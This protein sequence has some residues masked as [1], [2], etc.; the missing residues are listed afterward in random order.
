MENSSVAAPETSRPETLPERYA[1]SAEIHWDRVVASMV[2]ERIPLDI[3]YSTALLAGCRSGGALVSLAERLPHLRRLVAIDEDRDLLN[4]AHTVA[5]GIERPP[6]FFNNQSTRALN[7]ADN[8]F[9]LAVCVSGIATMAD[10]M[11]T[12]SELSRVVRPGGTVAMAMLGAESFSIIRE[13]ME[14]SA[15]ASGDVK[16]DEILADF[17]HARPTQSEVARASERFELQDVEVW[18]D[19]WA[20]EL[21]DAKSVALHPLWMIDLLEAW[22]RSV[23]GHQRLIDATLARLGV[24]FDGAPV[25]CDLHVVALVARVSEPESISVTDD[26]V[27]V[28]SVDGPDTSASSPGLEHRDEGAEIEEILDADDVAVLIDDSAS[29]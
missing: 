28:S 13:L 6:I 4:S 26:D 21:D 17:A 24:Y 1:Q 8:V 19:I 3:E 5:E 7:F 2:C 15:I 9:G 27:I 29:S 22:Q 12:L 10:F 25:P 11:N 16:Y 18:E 14:E 23:N 20:V